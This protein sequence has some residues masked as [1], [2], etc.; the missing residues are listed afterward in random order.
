MDGWPIPVS[1]FRLSIS[2][3]PFLGGGDKTSHDGTS[4]VSKVVSVAKSQ[5]GRIDHT[6]MC[7]AMDGLFSFPRDVGKVYTCTNGKKGRRPLQ[8]PAGTKY[9]TR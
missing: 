7:D 3:C 1:T 2:E 4:K 5:D 8:P 6:T 9:T